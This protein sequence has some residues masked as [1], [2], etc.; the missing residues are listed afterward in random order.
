[1]FVR[2]EV[3]TAQVPA[4]FVR[5]AFAHLEGAERLNSELISGSWSGSYQRGQVVMWLTFHATELFLKGFSLLVNPN[6]RITGHTLQKLKQQLEGAFGPIDFDI[7]FT[8]EAPEEH[9]H[10]VQEYE[11]T[12]HERFRYPTNREGVPWEGTVGFSPE[13]FASTLR[14]LRAQAEH[15]HNKLDAR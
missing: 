12:V 9:L 5:S 13:L 11:R 8:G 10:L 6:L 1:M 4:E 7:P 15:L 3:Q 14:Q 2:P